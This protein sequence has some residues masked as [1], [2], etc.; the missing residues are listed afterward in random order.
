M[1]GGADH[2]ATLEFLSR[3]LQSSMPDPAE[4]VPVSVDSY[5][6]RSKLVSAED[7]GGYFYDGF[8]SRY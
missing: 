8:E 2:L 1:V 6:Q 3:S 4:G 5:L 7:D